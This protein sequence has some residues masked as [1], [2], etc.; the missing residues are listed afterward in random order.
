M[1]P[2]QVAIYEDQAEERETLLTLLAQSAVPNVP[3]TFASGVQLL[4]VYHP[5]AFDLLLMDIYMDGMDGIR[6]VEQVRQM[7][8][9]VPVA[10]ITTSTDH[11][12]ES[13]RLSALMY[14]EKPVQREK[15]EE[16][17]Q[18]A[19]LKRD[20]A[21]S[22]AIY[23]RGKTNNLPLADILYL[24]QQARQVSIVLKDGQAISIYE[25][26]SSL[27]PQLESQPFFHSHKS[28]CVNLAYVMHIDTDLKCFVMENGEN[29][30]ILRGRLGG[31]FVYS[32][33][34]VYMMETLFYIFC[35]TLPS[36]IIPFTLFWNFPGIPA[37]L[38]WD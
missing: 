31:L 29:V 37:P 1:Q 35:T 14:L 13:Y 11:A 2:L 21:P 12:M 7:D 10:F 9:T 36:H 33:E 4:D 27:L 3:T 24:E 32:N 16:M 20:N 26:L 25:K 23:H 18:L 28:Y 5:R 30:P 17:L 19:R 34:G 8:K 38:H 22:L 15:I 6:T